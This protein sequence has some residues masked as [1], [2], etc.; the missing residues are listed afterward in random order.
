MN[1]LVDVVDVSEFTVMMFCFSGWLPWLPL[2]H[3]L[4]AV[5]MGYESLRYI[6]KRQVIQRWEDVFDYREIINYLAELGGHIEVE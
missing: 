5:Q 6:G 1:V 3:R 2:W 4:E